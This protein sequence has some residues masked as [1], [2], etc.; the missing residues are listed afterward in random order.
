MGTTYSGSVLMTGKNL[1]K[2]MLMEFINMGKNGE[3]LKF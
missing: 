1:S 2:E 3:P